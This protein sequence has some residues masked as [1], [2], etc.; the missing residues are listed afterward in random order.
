[1]LAPGFISKRCRRAAARLYP[2]MHSKFPTE[3][4]DG[5]RTHLSLSARV[6]RVADLRVLRPM[7]SAIV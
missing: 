5:A 1:M 4:S 3:C 2:R 7:T 6:E